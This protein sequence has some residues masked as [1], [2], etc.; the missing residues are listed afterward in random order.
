MALYDNLKSYL[1]YCL[2]QTQKKR[3]SRNSLFFKRKKG[4]FK[5]HF[6]QTCQDTRIPALTFDGLG[7]S[8]HLGNH[9]LSTMK[10]KLFVFLV[11]LFFAGLASNAQITG[12]V[13]RDYNL[14]GIYQAPPTSNE[15]GLEGIIINAYDATNTIIATT[16]STAN[17]TYTLP[18]TVPVRLEFE[19]PAPTLCVDSNTDFSSVVGGG[20]N[21]RF[22]NASTPN[23]N[24]AVQNPDDYIVSANPM[25]FI[26]KFN[27]GDPLVPGLSAGTLAFLSYPYST[28]GTVM[29]TVSSMSSQIGACWGVAYSKQ[30]KKVFTSAFLKRFAGLGPMGT[31]GIYLL[32]AAGP[33]FNVVQFYDMDA[34]GHRTRAASTAVAFGQGSSYTLNAGNSQA[35]Y[36]G[37]VDPLSGLPEGVGV[38][39]VN[40][41][42]GRG[43]DG[44]TNGQWYDAAAMDQVGKV[45][46]GDIDISEDGKFLFLT[47][48]YS[49]HV[50][51]LELDNAFNPTSVIKVDSFAL[52]ATIVAN[53]GLLR[54]F[55]LAYHRGKIFV[56]ANTTGEFGGQ[57]IVGGAT[58]LYAYVFEITNPLSATAA[59]NPTPIITFPLNYLKGA[60]IGSQ[61]NGSDQWYPWNGNTQAILPTGEESLPT[62][63]LS[64]IEFSDGGDLIM[65]FCDRSGHQFGIGVLQDLAVNT[66]FTAFD[67]GGDVLIAGIDCNTGQFT[68][69]SNG[70]FTSNGIV[71]TGSGVG[72]NE[73]PG[74]GE[75]FHQDQWGGGF[76]NE[77][78]VGSCAALRGR[79]EV[80]VTLMDPINAFSNGTGK[81]NTQ[82]GSTSGNAE[83]ANNDEFGKGNSLGDLEVAGDEV[84]LQIGNRVWKDDDGDGIQ[85]PGEIGINNVGVDIFADFNNDGAPDGTSLGTTQTATDGNYVFDKS[86]V[87]DGDPLTTGAQPGPVPGKTYLLRIASSDWS[88]GAGVNDLLSLS[89]TPSNIGGPGQPDVR[90]NDAI[91]L[92]AIPTISA[93]TL[94]S[95]QNIHSWDFGFMP[96]PNIPVADVYLDCLTD[97]AT[98]GPTAV[99]GTTYAW[100]P[101][102]GLSATNVAQPIAFPSTTTVYT[103][104][105]NS[106]CVKNVTVN[107][108]NSPPIVNP[109]QSKVLQCNETSTQIGSDPLPGYTYS[110]EPPQTLNDP[111]ISNPIASPLVTT[112]YTVTV[113]GPNGCFGKGAV[114]LNIDRCCAR[115][116]IPNSFTPNGDNKNDKFGPVILENVQS[117]YLTVYNR[118]GQRLFE[119]EAMDGKWDGTYNGEPCELGTYFYILKYNCENFSEPKM[120]KGDVTLIR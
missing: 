76:H 12:T 40:G 2:D 53:N 11:S 115:V 61:G 33:A 55:G 21:I 8:C 39:G 100:A 98:I 57:N 18:F 70:S 16:T 60:V 111:N 68:L 71:R 90:D 72:T 1:K 82:N 102:T 91:I 66:D 5:H 10:K 101:P 77:T 42:G 84:H 15:Y 19:F 118:W 4:I 59:L 24:Y 27:R 120:M 63:M 37:P 56:G 117:I 104:T 81:F 34:N 47:N 9:Q 119:T 20:E 97:S 3:S 73:G 85:D 112:T 74:G 51:R 79:N 41:P 58:D 116:S 52:P 110:W 14:D 106:L 83:L 69:E 65:D 80:L 46:I 7:S 78:S 105:V 45:G 30:A 38:V 23:V 86:N 96:C 87:A 103:L 17:G 113:T 93:T 25:I 108:D 75:F 29:P 43:L 89:L 94:K 67:I 109:G 49:R 13:F 36:L 95:G 88:A 22:I 54:C 35:T 48:L 44:N 28:S 62:P 114:T 32:E 50:F 31:G 64:D 92:S 99:A 6:I 107:V 26:P